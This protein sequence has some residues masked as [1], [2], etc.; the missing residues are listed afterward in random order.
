[1][2]DTRDVI[3]KECP[4]CFSETVIKEVTG[5]HIVQHCD[6]CDTDWKIEFKISEV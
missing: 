6:N 2:K 1:M 5:E 3:F 4:D